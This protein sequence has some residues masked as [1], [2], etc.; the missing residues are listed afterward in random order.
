M[1]SGDIES[2]LQ[3]NGR[4]PVVDLGNLNDSIFG[5]IMAR[6]NRIAGRPLRAHFRPCPTTPSK[7]PQ[8]CMRA[9][10]FALD[11]LWINRRDA[12]T[13]VRFAPLTQLFKNLRGTGRLIFGFFLI[14]LQ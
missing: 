10:T 1:L 14:C 8:P 4:L 3:Y 6:F 7:L 13:Y 12:F 9:M 11:T 2:K 5:E